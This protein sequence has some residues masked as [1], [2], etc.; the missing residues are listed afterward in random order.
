MNITLILDQPN[1]AYTNSVKIRYQQS[2]TSVQQ[3]ISNALAALAHRCVTLTVSENLEEELFKS[4]PD[5]VFNRSNLESDIPGKALVPAL[6]EKHHIPYT[7]PNAEACIIAS[8]KYLAKRVLAENGIATSKSTI[9]EVGG[10][11]HI[12]SNLTYPLFIK[13]DKGGSSMG[14]D[15][16]SLVFDAP[17]CERVCEKLLRQIGQPLLVEEFLPGREFTVGVLGNDDSVTFP[18]LE[19]IHSS[20]SEHP[21]RSFTSKMIEYK[22]E[23][24]I[25]PAPLTEQLEAHIKSAVLGAFKAVGC[26]DYARVDIRLDGRGIPNVLEINAFPEMIPTDSSYPFMAQ[27][28]GLEYDQLIGRILQEALTH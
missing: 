5:L 10:E 2:I 26:R 22:E 12:P 23:E 25:C 6:L 24:K 4:S 19:F 1:P 13:P 15:E 28:G 11:I 20:S 21:F 14:I 9:I 18:I 3:H 17:D 16:D 7:G 8:N 27:A